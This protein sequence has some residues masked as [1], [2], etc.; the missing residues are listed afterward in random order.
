MNRSCAV[1][2]PVHLGGVCQSFP[3]AANASSFRGA[4]SV[5]R[6][7][8]SGIPVMSSAAGKKSPSP[9][10][11]AA[12]RKMTAARMMRSL[13]F[14]ITLLFL[15]RLHRRGIGHPFHQID[16]CPDQQDLVPQ[17]G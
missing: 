12:K 2:G 17:N 1:S 7:V 8:P 6:V 10:V 13:D 9:A 3:T 4:T 14:H 11:T 5:P 16:P 15:G